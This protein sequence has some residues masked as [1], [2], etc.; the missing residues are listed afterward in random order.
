MD[1]INDCVLRARLEMRRAFGPTQFEQYSYLSDPGL[2]PLTEDD[3]T[4]CTLQILETCLVDKC[5]CNKLTQTYLDGSAGNIEWFQQEAPYRLSDTEYMKARCR[6]LATQIAELFSQLNVLP[7]YE[8][9]NS[10]SAIMLG[11]GNSPP[12][13]QGLGSDIAPAPQEAAPRN[14]YRTWF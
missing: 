8:S 6:D 13:V 2:E 1:I 14:P 7:G 12:I 11:P 3:Y 4:F 10:L 5:L 9:L